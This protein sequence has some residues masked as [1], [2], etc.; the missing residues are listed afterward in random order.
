MLWYVNQAE[1]QHKALTRDRRAQ[2]EP[3]DA[4]VPMDRAI[5]LREKT[6]SGSIHTEH[7]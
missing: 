7:E 3:R 1:L 6:T 4:R 5:E 2:E